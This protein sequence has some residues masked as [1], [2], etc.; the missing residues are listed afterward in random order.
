MKVLRADLAEDKVFIRRF[1]REAETLEKL[2]HPHI[3]RFYGVEDDGL[4][5][6]ML[7]D[8]VDGTTLRQK[9]RQQNQPFDAA[10]ILGVIRPVC[11]ALHYAHLHNIVHCDM[12]PANIM[13]HTNGAVFVSDFG[14][15]RLAEGATTVTMVGA[16][17]P[18]YMSPE[19][20]RGENPSPQ[21]DIYALGIVLYEMLTG[22]ERPFTGE[23]AQVT[24]T[25]GEKVRWEHIKLPPVPARQYNPSV[26]PEL[27]KII[28]KCLSKEPSRRYKSALEFLSAVEA[29][30]GVPST[31]T[32]Q[33]GAGATFQPSAATRPPTNP[34]NPPFGNASIPDPEP[35]RRPKRKLLLA[36]CFVSAAVLFLVALLV[37][38][39]FTIP[40]I[41]ITLP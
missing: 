5:V 22:G 20:I 3:V 1:M 37:V 4:N 6:F 17:T 24:G 34:S 18:A 41:T 39:Y 23:R 11:S 30:L 28:L 10:Q 12:K 33:L 15:S 2:Q 26:P 32:I 35:P 40:S 16:G 7:M 36:G 14:I 21:T 13:I 9:I 8:F 25:S 31:Q 19:Q 38:A 29:A 27:E